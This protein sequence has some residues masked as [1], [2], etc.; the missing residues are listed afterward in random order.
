MLKVIAC[1]IW[2]LADALLSK[3]AGDYMADWIDRLF[4]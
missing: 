3:Y 2:W 1:L 4:K